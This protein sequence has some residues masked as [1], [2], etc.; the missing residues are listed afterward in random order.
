MDFLS[1]RAACADYT[2][3]FV[4]MPIRMVFDFWLHCT[5]RHCTTFFFQ[6]L[7]MHLIFVLIT[8]QTCSHITHFL[9]MSHHL[10]MWSADFIFYFFFSVEQRFSIS[11]YFRIKSCVKFDE[12]KCAPCWLPKQG[13]DEPLTITNDGCPETRL[14][15]FTVT[16]TDFVPLVTMQMHP[17]SSKATPAQIPLSYCPFH[18]F[19]DVECWPLSTCVQREWLNTENDSSS[20]CH[21]FCLFFCGDFKFFFKKHFFWPKL[22]FLFFREVDIFC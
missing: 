9:P 18:D 3:L 17:N 15:R 21:L 20:H 14:F 16:S 2:F 12:S 13:R 1:K 10:E 7:Q 8:N 4:T 22:F 11:C 6:D 19:F 5:P